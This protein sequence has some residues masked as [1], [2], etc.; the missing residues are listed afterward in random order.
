MSR[1]YK[2]TKTRSSRPGWSVIFNHPRRSDARGK[3]GLKVRRGLGTRDEAIAER[4]VEQLNT[5]LAD[6]S[7]WSLDRRAEAMQQFDSIVVSLFYDGIEVGK[8]KSRDLRE[9]IIPLPTPEE[10]YAR[11]MLVGHTGAGKTTL[12]RQLIGSDP[13]RDRFP[14]TSTAKTTTADIEIVTADGPFEAA[15]TFMTEHEVRCAV[16]ECLEDAFTS[17][18]QG[19]DNAGIAEALLEHREQRFRLSY[20]LG[21]WQ[22][23]NPGPESENGKDE[24][25]YGYGDEEVESE[26]LAED[27][28]VGG[29]EITTNNTRLLDYVNRIKTVTTQVREEVASERRDYTEM[30]NANRRQD[31]LED[32]TDRLYE[33]QEFANISLDIM[34]AIEERF[35]L[36]EVGVFERTS[37]AWPT[38]W[39][40]SEVDRD[41][42]LKQV[43]WFTSNHDR[44][45]GR[46]LTPMV[47]GIRVRGPFR[48]RASQLCDDDRKLA[49]LDGEGL[50]HSAKEA[51]SIST[52]VTE[53]FP[54]TDMILLVDDAQSPMQAASLELL[55]SV[56]SS[57]HGHKLAVAFTHFDQ[58]KGDNI[59]T[60]RQKRNHVRASVRNATASLRESLGAPV[61]E[62]LDHQLASNDFY[63]GGLDQPTEKILPGFIADLRDLLDR[64]QKSA[65]PSEPIDLAPTYNVVRLELSLRDASDGFVAPWRGRLG[66]E[67]HEG[68]GKEHWA[69][70]KALCRRIANLWADEYNGLRPVADL[71]RQLQS[72]ISLWLDNPAGWTRQPEDED[73]RQAVI[74][75]IRQR[76]YID[77]HLLAERRLVTSHRGGWRRAFGFSG[78]GSSFD[79]AREMDRIYKSAAPSIT[80]VMNTPSQGF[81]DEVIE[82]VRNAVENVG[83][84]VEGVAERETAS[85]L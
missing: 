41:T 4:L 14:S 83:G 7:W 2:A 34:D 81:L 15:I 3:F 37:T 29:D 69:R 30:E 66:L 44:Q 11:V 20:P 49:L 77:I 18:V 1:I 24:L 57:G 19:R 6:E 60:H 45:F 80:S 64:M 25:D 52:K 46:L 59:S 28:T 35:A 68:I 21:A 50:G 56:G 54:E 85:T 55:R 84:S 27:E 72:S 58:V 73:E 75:A 42:F 63:L 78:L 76:V 8:L 17:V 40:F 9:S 12:L 51:T 23:E 82:I 74:N 33:S 16:D 71:V 67:Y 36:I 79:R 39:H 10:G 31:W 22:Q 53:K 38:S 32:F 13:R 43:R 5:L 47:D 65:E 61:T 26:S 62:I 48:P 70:V